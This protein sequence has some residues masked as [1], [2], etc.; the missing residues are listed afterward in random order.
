M[1][2]LV[3]Y[4]LFALLSTTSYAQWTSGGT[5]QG[6][7]GGN[8]R[9]RWNFGTSGYIYG[10]TDKQV[11]SIKNAIIG[12]GVDS[13]IY[14]TLNRYRYGRDTLQNKSAYYL[15]LLPKN[16]SSIPTPSNGV[17]FWGENIGNSIS[18]KGAN[19]FTA[20][21]N[22]GNA[23]QTNLYRLPATAGI[24]MLNPLTTA[25]D[26]L[27]QSANSTT[28]TNLTRRA[29]GSNGDVLTVSGGVPVWAAPTGGGAVTSVLGTTNRITV[30]PTTG[31]AVVDISPTFEGLLGKVAS[32]LS[33]FASTNSAQLRGV[34]SDE[35]G[36]GLA[37]FQGGDIGTPIAGVATNL[38]GTAAGLNIGG[39]AATSTT[40]TFWGTELYGGGTTTS[41]SFLMALDAVSGTWKKF[42]SNTYLPASG[43]TTSAINTL[44]GYTPANGANYVAKTGD[45]MSGGLVINKATGSSS[46]PNLMLNTSGGGNAYG[47]LFSSDA[48]HGLILRGYPANGTTSDYSVTPTDVMS[49]VDYGGE[50]RFY[51]KDGSLVLNAKID[52]NGFTGGV[53]LATGAPSLLVLTDA[54]K[55]LV[56][57]S[58]LPNGV[59]ATTQSAG[60]NS[61]KVATDEFVATAIANALIGLT[62]PSF[63]VSTNV[64]LY[65]S[66]DYSFTGTT[67][68]F[69]LPTVTPFTKG[70]TYS[71]T[72]KNRGSGNITVTSNNGVSTDIYTSSP[73]NTLTITPGQA[74]TFIQDTTYWNVE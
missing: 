58:A 71:I 4:A 35:T 68:T 74:V 45:T 55:N 41:T 18:F 11:D 12:G 44:Y 69:I 63:T 14:T 61:T 20:I 57:G 25:G 21:I 65:A 23:T 52:N 43:F 47:N 17:T 51:R 72:I 64:V 16:N 22:N 7:F 49:F 2:K 32:P 73:V 26:I 5:T 39:N 56:S 67:A 38:T 34:L 50:F 42:S 19:G 15:T 46:S 48:S 60:D 37:Y 30:S 33:Q 59:S 40:A 54:S 53:N 36:T 13:T 62:R 31:N 9:I 66:G 24:F 70:G 10:Y 3:L 6:R 1:K 28:G 27:Y 8:G 29:I